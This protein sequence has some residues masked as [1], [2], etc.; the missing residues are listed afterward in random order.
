ML[1]SALSASPRDAGLHYALG[2]ALIRQKRYADALGALREAANLAP[3]NAHNA[4][5]YA[6]ALDSAGRSPEARQV[7]AAA[8]GTHPEN[9]EILT[10]LVQL[11]QQANDLASALFYAERLLRLTPD[12]RDLER[13][14][15]QLRRASGR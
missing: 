8:L 7:L 3:E 9:R 11:S 10:A 1:R 15:D 13:Y 12:D 6:I 2:L 5:V 14:V 4:Y